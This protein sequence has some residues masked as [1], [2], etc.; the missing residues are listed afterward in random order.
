MMRT[1][2]RPR[3]LPP[4]RRKRAHLRSASAARAA[5][6]ACPSRRAG[7]GG[8]AVALPRH[9]HSRRVAAR[10]VEP[11]PA[12]C[13]SHPPRRFRIGADRLFLPLLRISLPTRQEACAASKRNAGKHRPASSMKTA[14]RRTAEGD[15]GAMGGSP[16]TA[17]ASDRKAPAL[18]ARAA[19]RPQGPYAVEPRSF[20]AW[21]W[22]RLPQAA[23]PS[24]ACA[25][26]FLRRRPAPAM[27]RLDAWVT[28]PVYTGLRR[29]CSPTAARRWER[30][31]SR[32]GRF[33]S[34]SAAN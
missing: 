7:V 6:L 26:H 33:Q 23:M 32:S 14:Q 10:A 22:R 34:L 4:K 18:A 16:R 13:A 3:R 5:E 27:L 24:I 31:R 15:R 9:P 25:P 19:H 11:A 12:A 8:A 1:S 29:S 20:L 17:V 28:P 30:A 2:S 21:S